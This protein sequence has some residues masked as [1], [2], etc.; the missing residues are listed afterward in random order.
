VIN[1]PQAAILAVSGVRPV[2][3]LSP[4]NKPVTVQMMDVTLST[5]ARVISQEIA[6]SFLASFANC[7]LAPAIL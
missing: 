1:P 3:T 7:L 2:V 6:S 5:D 4:D